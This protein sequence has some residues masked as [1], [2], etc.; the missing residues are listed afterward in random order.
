MLGEELKMIVTKIIELC[1][2]GLHRDGR[3]SKQWC[4]EEILKLVTT[5]KMYED[6][7][8]DEKYG[9]WDDGVPL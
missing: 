7:K 9:E 5:P 1:F 4:L 8:N 6:L 3:N 2:E